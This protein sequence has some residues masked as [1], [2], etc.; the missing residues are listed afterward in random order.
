MLLTANLC[1][2]IGMGILSIGMAWLIVDREGGAKLLGVVMVATTFMLFC[3]APIIG[4]LIDRVSRKS[5]FM[6]NQGLMIVII[7]PIAILG[8]WQDSLHTWQLV[9]LYSL[10]ILY[11]G[12]YFPNNTAFVQEIFDRS[13]LNRLN[14]M[15]EI[16]SQTASMISGGVSGILF[17]FIEPAPILIFVSFTCFISLLII[18]RIPY[19][20]LRKVAPK[21]STFTLAGF[22]FMK[23]H[24]KLTICIFAL[25]V[26]FISLMVGNYLRPV[27]IQSTLNAEA[28]V[29]GF[30][31][32][33]YSV[34]AVL[35]GIL[36]PIV[37][38]RWG[39]WRAALVA[40]FIFSFS[41]SIVATVPV[42]SLFIGMQL[43]QGVGNAGSRI[44]KQNIMMEVIPNDRIGRV[45][46]LFEATGFAI[47]LT[48]LLIFTYSM[49]WLGVETAFLVT[50]LISWLALAVLWKWRV[51]LFSSQPSVSAL[52]INQK[53]S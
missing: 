34:G 40:V 27:Y 5:I 52:T 37:Y 18:Y 12:V 20:N 4:Q 31:T 33:I 39:A 22:S 47:R 50:A 44:C 1:A 19:A 32:M 43:L 53:S 24:M 29:Y 30:S 9:L 17:Q 45:N 25:T 16:Q 49:D 23:Q 2:S 48:I 46:S 51:H 13:K 41:L 35:A 6:L 21:P 42:V 14:G 7:T 26:P 28:S 36:I 38:S 10:S 15:L 3:L 8:L 11:Y